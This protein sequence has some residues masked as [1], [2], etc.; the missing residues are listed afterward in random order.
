MW[1]AIKI[2]NDLK[3]ILDTYKIYSGESYN[4][5]IYRLLAEVTK[6]NGEEEIK[7]E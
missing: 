7:K 4:K 6:E 1:K 2:S 5:L 3:S